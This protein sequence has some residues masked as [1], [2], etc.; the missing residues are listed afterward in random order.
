MFVHVLWRGAANGH[1][2]EEGFHW[3]VTS[4][5]QRHMQ[6]LPAEDGTCHAAVRCREWLHVEEGG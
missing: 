3:A 4:R 5:R 2:E 6:R 1:A